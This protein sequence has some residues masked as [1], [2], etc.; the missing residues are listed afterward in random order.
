LYT[1]APVRVLLVEV[2]AGLLPFVR[3]LLV[4]FD[5]VFV[6]T[7]VD[8]SAVVSAS[9]AAGADLVI[10]AREAWDDADTELC[11]RLQAARLEVPL[12]A[13]SGPCDTRQR[14]GA[15]RAGADDFL[16]VP[17]EVDEL[18]ARAFAL[19]R[20]ASSGSRHARAGPFS[21]DYA[22]RQIFVEGKS[23]ALTLREYDLLA[24]LIE[25]AG[26]V[27][28]RRELSGAAVSGQEGESNVVDVHL[29]R[30]RD[31]LGAYAGHVET[32]RG[33]GYRL[34]QS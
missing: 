17:F 1:R 25:R 9:R 23:L 21:V 10:V 15:L 11:R 28:T 30:I 27:V 5:E 16:G 29:S 19:V 13:V 2:E 20:R 33:F 12:L 32:V 24:K 7:E 26:E 4:G 6:T 22:R 18:V 14:A 3:D 31:K 34:R 8:S